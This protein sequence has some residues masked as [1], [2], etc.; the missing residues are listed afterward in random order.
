MLQ[1]TQKDCSW[2]AHT[3][4]YSSLILLQP[5]SREQ[6]QIVF[7][8]MDM[9]NS[10][11]LDKEEFEQVM[12]ILFGNVLFRIVIQYSLTL[13]IVPLFAQMILDVLYQLSH[14]TCT[15]YEIISKYYMSIVET[16]ANSS[17][18]TIG[19][20]IDGE[21][22]DEKI[23]L[24]F[25]SGTYP[26]LKFVAWMVGQIGMIAYKIYLSVV[27]YFIQVI[28]DFMFRTINSI[29]TRV[30]NTL[31]ITFLSTVLG[32][33]V[34]PYCLTKIDNLLQRLSP[35]PPTQNASNRHRRRMPSLSNKKGGRS[36]GSTTSELSINSDTNSTSGFRHGHK[37]K[38][39]Q[40]TLRF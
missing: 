8:T 13:I 28:I 7:L 4:V 30:W 3:L 14:K 33:L 17:S 39:W 40:N 34:V 38:V 22:G 20:S 35:S 21:D 37:K 27:P 6:C 23:M 25:V 29:P 15:W 10:G 24:L 36:R 16:M 18:R 9:D 11:T 32:I 2:N 1:S 5:V 19:G 26:M 31:D 12:M